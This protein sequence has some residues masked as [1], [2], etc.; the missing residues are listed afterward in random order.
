MNSDSLSLGRIREKLFGQRWLTLGLLAWLGPMTG[1]SGSV[2][3]I[4]PEE[5]RQGS[6]N[7]SIALIIDLRT[8]NEFERGHIPGAINIPHFALETKSVPPV[9]A[10]AVYGD[11]LGRIDEVAATAA[12]DKKPGVQASFLSGGLAAWESAGF[13]TTHQ[14]G[15]AEAQ[16]PVI[17][18]EQ[19]K[20]AQSS[21]IVLADLR[22][23]GG[24]QRIAMATNAAPRAP[25]DLRNAFPGARVVEPGPQLATQSS[26]PNKSPAPS[27]KTSVLRQ[28]AGV[29]ASQELIVLIDDG[30]GSAEQTLLKLR[31]GGNK[32]VVILAGGE[33][34]LGR[35]GRSGLRRVGYGLTEAEADSTEPEPSNENK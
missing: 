31:S 35:E 22:T 7:K 9:G 15:L 25:T 28:L 11:G 33:T 17:T 10:I 30:D 23:R 32:R 24:S 16:L 12:I 26:G 19:L 18:Y 2:A 34:I 5:L 21:G 1:A 8:H 3:T 13:A 6:E 29:K 27:D 14:K 20:R 4:T